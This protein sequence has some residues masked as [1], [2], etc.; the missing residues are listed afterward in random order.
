MRAYKGITLGHK[1]LYL[2]NCFIAVINF[3]VI[4]INQNTSN[5]Q[6]IIPLLIIVTST[7]LAIRVKE[8][9]TLFFLIS[10]I[11]YINISIA[12]LDGFLGGELFSSYQMQL[13]TSVY[14]L[15]YMKS[16]LLNITI[17]SLALTPAMLK[18]SAMAT[19]SAD[20][21]S[22]KSNI[23][24]V[25]GGIILITL[26]IVFGY[27]RGEYETFRAS[28]R[29]IYEY[30]ILL[31]VIVWYYSGRKKISNMILTGLAVYYIV[32]GLYYGDRSSALVMIV[33]LGMVLIKKIRIKK[34]L[35]YGVVGILFANAIAVYRNLTNFDLV[36]IL[37]ESINK[38][39]LSL[40]SD[41]AS[42][43]YYTGVAIVATKDLVVNSKWDY[44]IKFLGSIF[45]GSSYPG[46]RE[47]NVT[48]V[49][50]DY[51]HVGGGGLYSSYFYFWGGYFGV[52]IGAILLSFIIRKVFTSEKTMYVLLQ[53][54][55]TVMAFRW[56]LYTPFTLFRT[57]ILMFFLLYFATK[58][59]HKITSK[60]DKN[61]QIRIYSDS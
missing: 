50:F 25:I 32:Q 53:Y 13:R 12:V 22:R 11:T 18:R 3:S 38:G 5:K 48:L 29:T 44:V 35:L 4:L 14:N 1:D 23:I 37:S 16:I 55:M 60:S 33:L 15:T 24:I 58:F 56:Y 47:A 39:I 26:F 34:M 45:V 9:K 20:D 41:T 30:A 59:I 6:L 28:A 54:Y 2:I 17:V 61:K 57:T 31:F 10:V 8:S 49:A 36:H 19:V 42:A 21:I 51:F 43:S 27:E 7:Y 52:I 40:F 46:L